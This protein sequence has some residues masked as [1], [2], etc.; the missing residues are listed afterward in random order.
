MFYEQKLAKIH[1]YVYSHRSCRHIS[2]CRHWN[3]R[4]SC[5]WVKHS[6][7]YTRILMRAPFLQDMPGILHEPNKAG[8]SRAGQIPS[9]LQ[10]NTCV[11]VWVCVCTCGAVGVCPRWTGQACGWIM[12]IKARIAWWTILFLSWRGQSDRSSYTLYTHLGLHP[13]I[14]HLCLQKWPAH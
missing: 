6:T 8:L 5:W 7:I 13:S 2:S 9:E 10:I 14:Q 12:C 1:D 11:C 4:T 3:R